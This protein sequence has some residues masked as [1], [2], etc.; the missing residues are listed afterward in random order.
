M[1]TLVFCKLGGSVLTDKERPR[2]ARPK[3]IARLA[4]ELAQALEARPGLRLV[5]GHGS[6]SFGHAV[7]QR[8]GTRAG[9]QG[10]EGWLG[11]V[12]V[13]A[14]AA[15][16][17]RIVTDMLLAAGLPV[18]S[19]A[20]SALARCEAGR[21]V[22]LDCEPVRE[23]LTRELVPLVYGDVALDRVLGGTI[24]STEQVLAYLARELHPQRLIL[25]SDVDGVFV[26]DPLSNPDALPVPQIT[27]ANWRQVQAA[28]GG[29]H[30]TDVTGGM[31]SKVEE[32][33][34]LAQEL[35]GLEVQIL[36]GER[37][38]ALE[39]A[40]LAPQEG[41]GGTVIRWKQ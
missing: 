33:V 22:A 25:V 5:L 30:A 15:R 3:V 32:M 16:L 1:S 26:G 19:L 40:L 36:S 13:A 18:W 14:E 8:T 35:P 29:S 38:G 39:G 6:G 21:L 41:L 28:L 12:Q 10:A 23:A 27:K 34:R 37:P 20:P 9:V 2:T 11:F 24:V 4:T 17:N 31:R 7:A